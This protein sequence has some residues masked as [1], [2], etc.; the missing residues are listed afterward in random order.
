M[1]RAEAIAKILKVFRQNGYEGTTLSRLS[2]A[3]GLG[4]ASLY[5][6]FPNGKE[7]MAQ[8]V[9]DFI[10]EWMKANIFVPLKS[11]GTPRDRLQQMSENVD[12]LYCG[13]EQ[14]CILAVLSLG[15]AKDLFHNQIQQ[16]LKSWIDTLAE[17]LIEAGI[18]SI[19]ARQRAEDAIIQIQG[20][21]VLARGMDDTTPF[22]RVLKQLPEMLL[23]NGNG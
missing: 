22:Q 3:T 8:A 16:A 4:K 20:S 6:Y 15:E 14:T 5:H 1:S 23:E 21:L 19:I 11:A 13:G 12:R 17:V 18:A 10:D 7:E 9:L 2:K